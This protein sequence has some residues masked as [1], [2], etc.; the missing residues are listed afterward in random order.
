M[1]SDVLLRAQ[2]DSS[3]D[4]AA[5]APESYSQAIDALITRTG[6]A[7]LEV[8]DPQEW[9]RPDVPNP[10]AR[11]VSFMRQ[12]QQDVARIDPLNRK[13]EAQL[14]RAIEFA[15][16]RFARAQAAAR[17]SDEAFEARLAHPGQGWCLETARAVI[18]HSELPPTLV[19]RW[20]ELHALRTEMVERSLYLVPL[21]VE[22]YARTGASRIDLIQEGCI[23]L[24]RAVDGFD[25]RRGLL[26]RTYAAHWL[27][28]AF[29]DHL[30]N[31]SNVIR[32]PIYVQKAMHKAALE[33]DAP[34][35]TTAREL[36]EEAG[37]SERAARAAN[38]ILRGSLSLEMEDRA[39][40]RLAD[41]IEDTRTYPQQSRMAENELCTQIER[42]FESLTERERIVLGCRFGLGHRDESTLAEVAGKLSLSIER[43]RQIQVSALAKLAAPTM[44]RRFEVFLN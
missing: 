22:R 41:I 42:A 43:V 30:Y 6:D 40:S 33:R 12:F 38:S 29:R 4:A 19:R 2:L 14:A 27:M 18:E 16:Q 26:F 10:R 31:F 44:R 32:V 24:Y 15:R 35:P 1:A 34:K 11:P 3:L 13:S 8:T 7:D 39:G 17:I 5:R 36:A 25:W 20:V 9:K 37:L 28:Q 23:A 21:N